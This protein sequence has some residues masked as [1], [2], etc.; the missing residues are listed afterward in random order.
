MPK[1]VLI[2]VPTVVLLLVLFSFCVWWLS[3]KQRGLDGRTVTLVS[4]VLAQAVLIPGLATAGGS[5]FY[6]GLRQILFS[7]PAVAVL[8]T[9]VVPSRRPLDQRRAVEPA[10]PHG[11]GP[12]QP[13]PA[14]RRAGAA[15]PYN[16][17]FTS[18]LGAAAGL[19]GRGDYWRTSL[20]ELGPEIPAD[21]HLVCTPVLGPDEEYRRYAPLA[22]PLSTR[23]TTLSTTP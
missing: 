13:G 22:Y 3:P 5:T 7:Y 1:T 17:A 18:E 8:M 20:R 16:Y 15:V 10:P 11:R 19:W 21:E 4:V 6:D 12:G 9:L 14:H 2:E 23:A